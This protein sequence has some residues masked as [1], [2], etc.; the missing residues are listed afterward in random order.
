[1]RA[2]NA[3]KSLYS[4]VSGA[5]TGE[6]EGHRTLQALLGYGMMNQV[7]DFATRVRSGEI[8][9]DP[10]TTLFFIAGGL[11][12]KVLPMETTIANLGQEI[13]IL[14]GLGRPA[15]HARPAA[16]PNPHPRSAVGK[17]LNP[18]IAR[19]VQQG[20]AELGVDLW[21]NHWGADF[22]EV[23]DHPATLRNPR[24][25]RRSAPGGTSATRIR[26]RRATLPLTSAHHR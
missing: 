4:R 21:L 10:E 3:A 17:R 7:R 22:D 11:N 12:D 15:L 5:Q 23:M 16:R 8:H 1:M 2:N 18:A 19:L 24:T 26:L 25:R 6:G 14:Q 13:V 9:F 20:R